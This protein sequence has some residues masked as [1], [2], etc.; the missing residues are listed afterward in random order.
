M[1]HLLTGAAALLSTTSL[2]YA[3]GLDRSDQPVDVIFQDGGYAE[4]SIGRVNPNQ[5]GTF[6]YPPGTPI[7]GATASSGD[8]APS[9]YQVGAAIKWDLSPQLSMAVIYD[10]PFGAKVSYTEGSPLYPLTGT[11]ANVTSTGITSLLRYKINDNFSVHGGLR[12]VSAEADLTQVASGLTKYTLDVERGSGTGFVVGAAYERP[13]I[14]LRAAITYSSAIEMEHDATGTAY[15][16]ALGVAVP[17]AGKVAYDLPQSVNIDLQTGVAPGTL[18]FA[19]IR[20]ADWP[21]TDVNGP[22]PAPGVTTDIIDYSE[23]AWSYSIGVG[24]QF[25][26][27]FAGSIAF[28]WEPEQGGLATNL[29]PSDGV[30]SITLGGK[31]ALSENLDLSAGVSYQWRGS[32]TVED[33]NAKFDDNSLVGAG[34]KIAYKF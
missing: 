26:D 33:I 15:V 17:F 27:R 5:S 14:A 20:W 21:Q 12:L 11:I 18:V 30:K 23:A 13:E 24:R 25:S 29:S 2:A 34:I 28:G 31:F 10:Q 8:M 32:A 6:T 7:A 19:N 4:M 16:D 22:T 9:Y 3:A 1:K